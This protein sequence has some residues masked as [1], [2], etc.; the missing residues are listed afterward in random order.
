MYP[1]SRLLLFGALVG[2]CALLGVTCLAQ[3]TADSGHRLKIPQVKFSQFKLKNGLRVVLAPD[4]SAP[5]VA[6]SVTYDVGSRNERPGR[7]GFAHLFEHLMFQ[8]SENIGRGEHFVLVNDN[9]GSFN[10]TTNADRTNFFETLPANQLDL[11]L[12][13]EADRMRA[14]DINKDN[15]DNQRLVVQEERRQRYD[16]QP[17][18][19]FQDALLDLAF[20][21]FAY[22]HTTIGSMDDLNAA[23]LDD[24]KAFYQTYYAPNNAVLAVAGDFDPRVAKTKIEQYFGKLA[25]HPDPPSLDVSEPELLAEKRQTVE[26]KLARTPRLSIAFPTVPGNHPDYYALRILSS[27]LNQGRQSRLRTALVTTNLAQSANA[28]IR[29]SRGISLFSFGVNMGV[30]GDPTKVETAVMD[31]IHKVQ[32]EGPTPEELRRAKASAQTQSLFALQTSLNRANTLAE[33]AVFYNDPGRINGLLPHLEAVTADDVRR[34]AQKYLVEKHRL[35]V[36]GKPARR[37]APTPADDGDTSTNVTQ[38]QISA[39]ELLPLEVPQP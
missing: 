19:G 16:N 5:V 18:S 39:S 9:G 21:N 13:L 15:L 24:V 4:K 6:V 27:V 35:I 25:K 1:L 28:S 3:E 12:Y 14:L 17:Y 34:V 2:S 26:D 32:T 23:T 38:N 33:Y 31:V 30:T 11:A 22:K 10:G 29:E 36:L 8:G 20:T 37:A 7:T